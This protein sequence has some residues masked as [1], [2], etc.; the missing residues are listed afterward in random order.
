LRDLVRT[1]IFPSAIT[2]G[3]VVLGTARDRDGKSI[4]YLAKRGQPWEQLGAAPG[5]YATGMNSAGDVVGAVVRD[6]LEQPWLRRASGEM[7]SL[8][9]FTYHWCRPL[10]INDLGIIV[11]TAQADHGMHALV[12]SP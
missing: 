3:G 10:A 8:P 9:Y 1:W 2:A 5:F 12:W 4:A 7:V 11:G 6:G